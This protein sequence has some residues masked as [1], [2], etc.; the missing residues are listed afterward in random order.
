MRNLK[1]LCITDSTYQSGAFWR[2]F[3]PLLKLQKTMN[4]TLH[5][6]TAD[7]IREDSMEWADIVF[8]HRPYNLE[9]YRSFNLAKDFGIPIWTDWDDLLTEIP[10]DNATHDE[11]MDPEAIDRIIRMILHSD[12]VSV[13]TEGMKTKFNKFRPQKDCIILNNAFCKEWWHWRD[14]TK[15][16][17]DKRVLWRGSFHHQKDL[18]ENQDEIIRVMNKFKDFAFL[19]VGFKPWFICEHTENWVSIGP[20]NI[21]QYFKNIHFS[22]P[23]VVMVPLTDNPFNRCKS[24]IAMIEGAMGGGMIVAPNW[25]EWKHP[26][27][28]NYTNF[29]ETLE[30]ACQMAQDGVSLNLA[31]QTWKHVEANFELSQWNPKRKQIIER[32]TGQSSESA[33]L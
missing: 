9:H 32:L 25:E 24:N 11:Y 30:Q 22:R 10:L 1:I 16:A 23:D 15:R 8:L 28:L 33:S 19:F 13:S 21:M 12:V 5:H 4:I 31:E 6:R 7:L 2:S 29:G 18:L 17:P 3:G 27:V 20:T 26:G 14:V